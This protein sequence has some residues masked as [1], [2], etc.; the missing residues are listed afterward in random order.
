MNYYEWR[1]EEV[2]KATEYTYEMIQNTEKM[3]K[4]LGSEVFNSKVFLIMLQATLENLHSKET[5]IWFLSQKKIET[6]LSP[7]SIPK[8]TQQQ[9]SNEL[10]H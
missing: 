5:L 9:T 7:Y 10:N 2:R 6:D 8:E 4:E 3:N 1:N